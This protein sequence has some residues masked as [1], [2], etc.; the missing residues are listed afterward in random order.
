MAVLGS[1]RCHSVPEMIGRIEG[2]ARSRGSLRC[3]C[4]VSIR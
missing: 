2:A 1:V 3:C 4:L